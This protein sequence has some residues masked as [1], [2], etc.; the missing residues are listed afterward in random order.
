MKPGDLGVVVNQRGFS[1]YKE[2]EAAVAYGRK[3]GEKLDIGI[4]LHY[5]SISVP[6]Y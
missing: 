3:L 6:G 5:L 1:F 2:T 4:Q